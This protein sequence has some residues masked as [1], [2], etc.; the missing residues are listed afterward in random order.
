MQSE[1][2]T[3]TVDLANQV[4]RT[5]PG[6]QDSRSILLVGASV[7]W[8]AQSAAAGGYRVAGMD[9][10]GDLD[11]RAACARFEKITPA[12]YAAPH[13]LAESIAK[14]ADQERATVVW[15]GGLRAAVHAP[16]ERDI[17]THDERAA[18][19]RSVGFRVPETFLAKDGRRPP[20][21]RW[22]VKEPASTGGLGIQFEHH[23]ATRTIPPAAIL[24]RWIPGR[25]VGLV[26]LA[27]DRGVSLLGMTRSIHH[28]TGH[29]P[30]VYAGSRTLP[31]D[32][33][34]PW[35]AMQ[36]MCERFVKTRGLRGLFNL[37][38]IHDRQ[39]QWWLLEINERPS[40]SCEVLERAMRQNGHCAGN[41]SLMRWHFAAVQSRSN[42]AKPCSRSTTNTPLPSSSIHVKRIVYGR[43]HGQVHLST[44]ARTWQL[45]AG[46]PYDGEA[47]PRLQIADIP[48]DGTP[49]Q[50]G[51]PIA[52][53]LIDSESETP[54]LAKILRRGIQ[55]IESRLERLIDVSETG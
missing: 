3:N 30:F 53:L 44:L 11:T 49:V 10:F 8:A 26:A 14:L 27:D 47:P 18:L 13:K 39:N 36:S 37:D 33:A 38:W 29:L 6:N 54:A 46:E 17:L 41:D 22:L 16:C 24:Q 34:V 12:E 31:D 2:V 20:G 1:T 28:R 25:P 21:A 40:A 45:A 15:I 19:A 43:W 32:R 52:T 5:S 35:S 42:T 51:Q 50:R 48:A 23:G 9:L 7:R 4:T 55:Q